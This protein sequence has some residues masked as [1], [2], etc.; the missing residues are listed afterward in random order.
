MVTSATQD[1]KNI[2]I[3]ERLGPGTVSWNDDSPSHLARYYFAS[4]FVGGQRVLDAGTGL[5]Y[6]A[7]ILKMAGAGSVLGVDIDA[8]SV[9]RARTTY[10][11][12]GLEYLVDDCE[13][14]GRA[15]GPFDV[16][17]NFENIEHL[18]H[19]E[20]FL[21]AA[22]RLLTDDGVLL[23]ST[24]DRATSTWVNGRPINPYHVNEWYRD[25]FAELLSRSFADVD[26]RCQV[27]TTTYIL[28][29]KAILNLNQH[30]MYLW[31]RPVLRLS[32]AL[33]KLV[34][35]GQSWPPIVDLVAP[36]PTDYPVVRHAIADIVGQSTCH[37]AVCRSPRR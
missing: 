6:G 23:C 28:R 32:R 27:E 1:S 7:A 24:P 25:E 12:D 10:R 15:E 34:G 20:R 36:A 9:E 14:L 5:G 33:G 3:T 35:K 29:R 13:E 30:L 17:C 18:N 31:S 21:E 8:T 37:V 2:E 19:P 4:E 16:I 11:I 22:A 26:L